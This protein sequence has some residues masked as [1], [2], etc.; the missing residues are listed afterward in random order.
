MRNQGLPESGTGADLAVISQI[1]SHHMGM[2]FGR[3]ATRNAELFPDRV[4]VVDGERSVTYAELE[5]LA[6]RVARALQNYGLERGDR[7]CALSRNCLEY[8]ALLYGAAKIGVAVV[9][10][11]YRLT[12]PEISECL[13]VTEPRLAV[14]DVEFAEKFRSAVLDG[15]TIEASWLVGS[16]ADLP[17]G[18]QEIPWDLAVLDVESTAIPELYVRPSDP[19]SLLYTSGSSGTPKAAMISHAALVARGLMVAAE[20]QIN[21]SHTFIAWPPLFHMGSADYV[22]IT[23]LLGGKVVLLQ[24]FDVPAI[25]DCLSTEQLGWLMLMP[26]T[27]AP[28]IAELKSRPR[29]IAGVSYVGAMADLVP[30][31]EVSALEEV[32][33]ARFLNT[34]GSTEAGTMPCIAPIRRRS[35]NYAIDLSKHQ[36]MFCDVRLVDDEE[37]DVPVGTPGEMWL[38]GPTLFAG[39]YNNP[40]ANAEAFKDGW[41]RTGDV[42]V[43][44]P[45]GSLSFVDRKKY[46][47]KSGGENIYPAEV[48]RVLQRHPSVVEVCVVRAPSKRWGETPVAFVA[49]E[50]NASASE[51]DLRRHCRSNLAHYKV[52][53]KFVILPRESLPRNVTGKI[54]RGE[55]E[56][57]A[58]ESS[59][60]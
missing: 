50:T 7:V 20:L 34:F 28:V 24:G 10:L 52:P 6:N 1:N 43:R 33:G 48:E 21:S 26:G 31:A 46:L 27:I 14:V 56:K 37:Q 2:T 15:S 36:S 23:G 44:S 19:L 16:R 41:F 45:D 39:Y 35:G 57:R 32:V 30:E 18:V 58:R 55:L 49:L 47:I 51:E 38:R 11:N 5:R 29:R 22:L 59:T 9:G 17:G 12:S 42:L 13:H 60:R 4:A 3:I 8:V 54:V 40:A 53:S 25:V